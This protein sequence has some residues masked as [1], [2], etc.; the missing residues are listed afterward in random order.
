MASLPNSKTT[1][2]R[3]LLW[4]KQLILALWSMRKMLWEH[5]NKEVHGH[6]QHEV[7]EKTG[8]K[9]E[10]KIRHFYTVYHDNL[11]LILRGESYLFDKE[12][13]HHLLLSQEHQAAWLRSVKEA[14][15]IRKQHEN[16]AAASRQ[17]WFKNFFL[18][19]KKMSSSPS[20]L[21]SSTAQ[22]P[23]QKIGRLQESTPK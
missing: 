1:T 11:F 15:L 18:K 4:G 5:R 19:S 3:T 14:I 16:Q 22:P 20:R 10:K 12:F 17:Q 6:S 23:L 9:L 8:W 7:R 21:A 2:K 13:E